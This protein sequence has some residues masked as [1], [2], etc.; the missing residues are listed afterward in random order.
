MPAVTARVLL[1][2][3]GTALVAVIAATGW[4]LV[5][6]ST[7]THRTAGAHART[8]G[9]PARAGATAGAPIVTHA[10]APGQVLKPVSAVS[11]DPYGDGQGENSQ[12]AYLAI[13]ASP[14]TAWSTE[15]YA[16][17]DFGNLKPGTGLLLDMGRTVT[18]TSVQVLLGRIPG[19][20]FQVRVGDVASLTDLP[21]VAHASDA[22]G[23]VSLH[24]TRPAHGRYVLIW[25]TQ[26]PPDTSGTFRAS[27]YNVSL[28][29]QR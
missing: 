8:T 29:G 2:T 21:S 23:Q 13:D 16:S 17:A 26:L 9:T 5:H 19:A 22:G 15:W 10:P 27:V 20:D 6:H 18:I 12:L 1:A 25:F 7:G 24:L 14:A 28:E 4:T 11:F 3:G